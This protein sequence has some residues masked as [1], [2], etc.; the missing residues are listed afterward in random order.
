MEEKELGQKKLFKPM[1]LHTQRT[2]KNNNQYP[3]RELGTAQTGSSAQL[4][5]ASREI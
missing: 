5:A 1:Q 2:N 3:K 4:E